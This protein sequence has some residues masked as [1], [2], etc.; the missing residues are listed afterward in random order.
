MYSIY[1]LSFPNNKKYIGLTKL[2]PEYRWNNGKGYIGGQLV[3]KAIEKYGWENVI[4]QILDTTDVPE[5]AYELEKKYIREY[6]TTDRSFGYNLSLGGESGSYG[7]KHT[8]EQNKEKSIRQTGKHHKPHTEE[9]KKLISQNRKGKGTDKRRK[10]W[11]EHI[12]IAK[13]KPISLVSEN[14]EVLNF[15]SNDEAMK[16]LGIARCTYHRHKRSKT[17]IKGYFIQEVE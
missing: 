3:K 12:S 10:E 13:H 11:G 6:K 5:I 16:F 2:K 7:Y 14:N 4:H 9:T 17:K 1:M 8:P 15:D